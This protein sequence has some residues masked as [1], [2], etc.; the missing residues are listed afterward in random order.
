MLEARSF[1]MVSNKNDISKVKVNPKKRPGPVTSQSSDIYFPS[2]PLCSCCNGLLTV[3][4]HARC[5]PASGPLHLLLTLLSTHCIDTP[6]W[7]LFFLQLFNTSFSISFL[8]ST[9]PFSSPLPHPLFS[10]KLW[11]INKTSQSVYAFVP[12][13][14]IL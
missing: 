9:S 14:F 1:R 4:Y 5:A 2:Y 3:P 10:N 11:L 6:M 7:S 12:I 13:Q 8:K